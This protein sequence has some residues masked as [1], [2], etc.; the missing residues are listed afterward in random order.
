MEIN[1]IDEGILPLL[2]V[3]T[4]LLIE[5]NP[6]LGIVLLALFKFATEERLVRISFILLIIVLNTITFE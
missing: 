2:D 3:M 6:V 5:D 1:L 4:I